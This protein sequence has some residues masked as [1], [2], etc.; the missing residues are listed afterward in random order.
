[1]GQIYQFHESYGIEFFIELSTFHFT[2]WLMTESLF[3]GLRNKSP[4]IWVGFHLPK[5]AK[6]NHGLETNSSLCCARHRNR[7]SN[8]ARDGWRAGQLSISV[9]GHKT[10]DS[11]W[12]KPRAVI[13][14]PWD[15][16]P[17]YWLA[18]NRDPYCWGDSYL[19]DPYYPDW[20]MTGSLLSGL[21]KNHFWKN[22]VT[23]HL[24]TRLK[25]NMVHL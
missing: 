8:F 23:S 7:R 24:I 17:L 14:K 3:D 5:N 19:R 13:S 12:Q 1:M 25:I 16:I 15:D 10:V 21:W 22:L 4:Y 20:F 2:G 9:L 11:T 6:N 18:I